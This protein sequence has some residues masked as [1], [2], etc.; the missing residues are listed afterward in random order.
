MSKLFFI[1]DIFGRP[2]RT[3]LKDN[4][5]KL[6]Q[7]RGWDIVVA[8]GENAAGGAGITAAIAKE[9]LATGIDAI[10]LG[11][12]VW[13]QYEFVKEID[14][15]DTVSR[16]ANLHPSCPGK[17]YLILDINGIRIGIV[18]VLGQAFMR[19]HPD[20]PM[21]VLD[22]VL[23][24]FKENNVNTIFAEI[25]AEATAEKI[26]LGW[27]LD[28]KVTLVAGTHT[29]VPT[30]DATILPGGTA[31]ITDVGMTG[32]YRSVIGTQTET[33]LAKMRDEMPRRFEVATDDVRISGCEVEF[34]SST[35]RATAIQ[36]LHIRY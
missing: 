10:T 7:E 22:Q 24:V 21:D 2:G 11:D 6:R 32:P 3:V 9:L 8:N 17:P 18:T 20:N 25:H 15:L 14:T 23:S 5:S 4:L 34:D 12:H 33:I 31:Y 35:G 36:L 30:A 19:F 28:G 26:A 13:D 1:G 29:H 27:Y 16:P